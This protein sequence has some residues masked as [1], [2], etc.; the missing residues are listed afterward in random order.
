[1][2][3]DDELE[4]AAM[5]GV[6]GGLAGVL[7]LDTRCQVAA[8]VGAISE[9]DVRA[10]THAVVRLAHGDPARDR[11]AGQLAELELDGRPVRVGLAGR[12]VI[13]VGIARAGTPAEEVTARTRAVCIEIACSVSASHDELP[14][15]SWIPP[16]NGGAGGASGPA[17][18]PVVELDVTAGVT[19]P[20]N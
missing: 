20:K 19:R 2:D 5:R 9:A 8:P 4:Q 16:P 10:L 12:E 17:Q 18:L 7:L 11:F 14:S 1:M 6:R 15:R 13:V 3:I